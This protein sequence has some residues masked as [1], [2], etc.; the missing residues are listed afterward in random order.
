M[1][2][3]VA[4]KKKSGLWSIVNNRCPH[5][6]EGRLFLDNN[7]YNLKTNMDMPENCP[8]CGQKYELQTGFYF[9]TGYVS[10]ALSVAVLATVFVA[11]A[12][13]IGLTFRDNSIFYCLGVSI[14]VLLLIQ[15]VL[16]RLARSIWIAIFVRY[17]PN[18][19]SE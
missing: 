6:R 9:G 12:V 16:Q 5:C 3:Q 8:V 11:Y 19:Q 15:P 17:N 1:C 4:P 10:Y 7:P 14:G 18:W 2:A 13:L